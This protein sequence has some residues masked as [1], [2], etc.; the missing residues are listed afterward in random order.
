LERLAGARPSMA[1]AAPLVTRFAIASP[2]VSDC[3]LQIADY[4]WSMNIIYNLQS[5]ICSG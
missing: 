5:A 1:G 4:T 3:R 2:S